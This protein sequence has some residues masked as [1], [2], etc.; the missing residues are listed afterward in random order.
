MV[1]GTDASCEHFGGGRGAA[2]HSRTFACRRETGFSTDDAGEPC[3]RTAHAAGYE[4]PTTPDTGLL[5]REIPAGLIRSVSE[6]P[7][8]FAGEA[9]QHWGAVEDVG[10]GQCFDSI[11]ASAVNLDGVHAGNTTQTSCTPQLSHMRALSWTAA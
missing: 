5:R 9:R 11:G 1:R 6:Q 4:P 3:A 7:A 8:E 2:R 10:R